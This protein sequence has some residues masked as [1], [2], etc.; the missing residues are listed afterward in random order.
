MTTFSSYKPFLI[1]KGNPET[2]LF[3][4]D[5]SW[6]APEDAYVDIQ[7]AYVNRG[8]IVK[9]D[10]QTLLGNLVYDNSQILVMAIGD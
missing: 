7:D 1:G 5:E 8:E 3:Q 6:I 4:Y 9:R 2:G 10:G